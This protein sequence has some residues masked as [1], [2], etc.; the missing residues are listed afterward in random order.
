MTRFELGLTRVL[1]LLNRLG[2]AM[3]KGIQRRI[4]DTPGVLNFFRRLTRNRR[5]SVRTPEGYTLIYNPLFH[6][7]LNR[8]GGL[9][10]YEP[11]LRA[12]L[13]SIVRPGMVAYDIGANV[14]A[15]TLQL[16]Y[17]VGESGKVI[18]FEP[19]P[20]NFDCLVASLDKSGLHWVT[21]MRCAIAEASGTARFDQ[22]GGAFSGRLV[23]ANA[24]YAPTN[25]IMDVTTWSV[26]DLVRSSTLP[27]PDV[28]KL[29]VEG[30]EA[31]VIRG[32]RQVMTQYSPILFC[33]LHSHLGDSV[34]SVEALLKEFGYA[35]HDLGTTSR[36][37]QI[38]AKRQ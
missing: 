19:D 28:V 21:P 29:D 33:E 14:G 27:A 31:L 2:N 35:W 11:E 23:T 5:V 16:A 26:D 1:T 9:A 18:A 25:N 6:A 32:M 34:S 24:A 12:S 36:E 3:P 20:A 4:A 17:L 8:D 38:V 10:G 13:A 7:L 22:R 37:R 15:F 30:N